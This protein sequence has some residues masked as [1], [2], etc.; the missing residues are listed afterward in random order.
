MSKETFERSKPRLAI[1]P[2]PNN[3]VTD[4]DV[5]V[6]AGVLTFD[7]TFDGDDY[8]GYV[9]IVY[10]AAPVAVG[11]MSPKRSSLKRLCTMENDGMSGTM[12]LSPVYEDR[13]GVPEVGDKIWLRLRQVDSGS[14]Q[15]F[16]FGNFSTVVKQGV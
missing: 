13:F 12:D 16:E 5:S 1:S 7:V 9:W 10:L 2:P 15:D 4:V 14:G 8:P 11:V 6:L 3:N